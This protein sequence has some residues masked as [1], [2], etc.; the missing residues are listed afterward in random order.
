[1]E[2]GGPLGPLER[3]LRPE[4]DAAPWGRD[5]Q[6]SGLLIALGAVLLPRW[7]LEAASYLTTVTGQMASIYLPMALAMLLAMRMGAID[8]SVWASAA[9][10]GAVTA[11]LLN[12]QTPLAPALLT[13][14]GFGAAIGLLNAILV[15]GLRLPSLLVTPVIGAALLWGLR[16]WTGAEGL[17]LW[18]GTAAALA[19]KVK[20]SPLVS[21]MALVAGAYLAMLGGLVV[22]RIREQYREFLPSEPPPTCPRLRLAGALTVG[23]ALAAWGGG[24]WLTE[25]PATPIPSWPIGDYRPLAACMLAGA[26]LLAGKGRTV[27]AV[28]YLPAS[29][30]L[31]TAWRQ[32]TWDL[33]RQGVAWQLA[34][35]IGQAAVFQLAVRRADRP[36]KVLNRIAAG[37]AFAGVVVLASGGWLGPGLE[38]YAH[39]A[40]AAISVLAGAMTAVGLLRQ[41]RRRKLART[42]TVNN[43]RD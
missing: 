21:R 15:A 43:E 2:V 42:S 6:V 41:R 17:S 27:L 19:E 39:L 23:G 28:I 7:D 10:G 3:T 26:L 18:P 29:L 34:V 31:A 8:L 1:M 16:T 9:L 24:C 38:W 40:G 11:Q 37:L 22:G 13:G 5:L 14:A 4:T 33:A 12:D 20:G 36:V 25:A 35:L 32:L 30:L